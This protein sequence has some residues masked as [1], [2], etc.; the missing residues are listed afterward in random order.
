MGASEVLGLGFPSGGILRFAREG[1]AK[2]HVARR[3]LTALPIAPEASLRTWLAGLHFAL[4]PKSVLGILF[5]FW[6]MGFLIYID[7][8]GSFFLPRG[9]GI[10][11]I[12]QGRLEPDVLCV[13]LEEDYPKP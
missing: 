13:V 12:C 11:F 6:V 2:R 1:G 4:H 10:K 9:T 8:K 5:T 7:K 3:T